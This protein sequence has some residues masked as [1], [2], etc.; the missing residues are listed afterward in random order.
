MDINKEIVAI[1][2]YCPTEETIS[3]LEKLILDIQ[4]IRDKYSVLVCSGT[5]I[6]ERLIGMV[7]FFIYDSLNDVLEDPEYLPLLTY[8]PTG[9][10]WAIASSFFQ[11]RRNTHIPARWKLHESIILSR[12]MGFR[13]LH[14]FEFD[15]SICFPDFTDILSKSSDSI[16]NDGYQ[17]VNFSEPGQCYLTL[18]ISLDLNS[19]FPDEWFNY[20]VFLR[21][22]KD[23][24]LNS[25]ISGN[26]QTE[27]IVY[28]DLI[29]AFGKDGILD[30]S[31]DNLGRNKFGNHTY[32]ELFPTNYFAI[33]YDENKGNNSIGVFVGV[34]GDGIFNADLEMYVND[35]LVSRVTR[36]DNFRGW[37]DF[38]IGM[39]IDE[40]RE[41][42]YVFNG[43][44]CVHNFYDDRLINSFKANSRKH[45]FSDI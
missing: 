22:E 42:K 29:N 23:K 26:T 3:I 35:S 32:C 43:K 11:D 38:Y 41:I 33:Y 16:L 14:F 10:D 13:I 21:S 6:P 20:H 9:V 28:R 15:S 36:E 7:D 8:N 30:L 18:P 24:I 2:S 37:S 5:K 1:S 4:C 39:S 45:F 34:H 27:K 19:K 31:K 25:R 44:V 40:L 17:V 12:A